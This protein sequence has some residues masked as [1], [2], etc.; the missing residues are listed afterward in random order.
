MHVVCPECLALGA[1]G[2][3]VPAVPAVHVVATIVAIGAIAAAMSRAWNLSRSDPADVTL[4]LP[5]FSQS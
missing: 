4:Y 5:E 3:A 1:L 2:P